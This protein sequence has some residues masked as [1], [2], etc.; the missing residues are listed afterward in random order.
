MID[1]PQSPT[2]FADAQTPA[3]DIPLNLQKTL[4]KKKQTIL[5]VSLSNGRLKAL[6]IVKNTIGRSWERPGRHVSLDTLREA[7]EEAI[8]RTQFPGTHLAMLVDHPRL[9]SRTIQIPPMLLTDLLP[10]LERKVQQENRGR[11]QRLGDIRLAWK[12]EEN[13][14]FTFIYGHKTIS[15]RSCTSAMSWAYLFVSWLLCRL[16]LRVNSARCPSNREKVR[17]C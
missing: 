12:H 16:W 13:Y 8:D 14:I 6:S 11:D 7:L 1:T 2:S 4:V 5:S 9:A 15:I 3:P 17:S 10:F